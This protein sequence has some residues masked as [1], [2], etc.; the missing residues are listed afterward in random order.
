MFSINP[1]INNS[2]VLINKLRYIDNLMP[3]KVTVV[4]N[5][6]NDAYE[7]VS[8]VTFGRELL[9]QSPDDK[10][11]DSEF[12][13]E[14]SDNL[15]YTLD[16][17]LNK[18]ELTKGFSSKDKREFYSTIG[19]DYK[20]FAALCLDEKPSILLSGKLDYFKSTDNFDVLH[21]KVKSK[22]LNSNSCFKNTMILNKPLAKKVI[23]ENKQL[24]TQRLD[25]NNEA[26][27][28]N[29]YKKIIKSD[30]ISN[31]NNNHDLLGV[32]LGFSPINSV[33]F[34]L[35]QQIPNNLEMREN[36]DK[37]R[38]AMLNNLLS[39]K[40]PYKDFNQLFKQN[41]AS[42][43]RIIGNDKDT[44]EAKWSEFGH[45]YINIVPDVVHDNKIINRI[46][47]TSDKSKKINEE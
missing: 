8:N 35:D 11:F 9:E 46:K 3:K 15:A 4:N 20:S 29:I 24:F 18:F 38:I 28:D 5:R 14:Y 40:S 22:D 23:E 16:N 1:F 12:K 25:L 27:V 36:V 45:T 42:K 17:S 41:I 33:L 47:N 31:I 21:L 2:S 37:Y 7:V 44:F 26:S 32:L 10:I 6:L 39:E 43:I 13:D 19:S 30:A 34:H